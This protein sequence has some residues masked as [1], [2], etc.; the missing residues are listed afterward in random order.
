MFA[1]SPYRSAYL[2]RTPREKSYSSRNSSIRGVS[3]SFFI[4]SPFFGCRQPSI[5]QTNRV[6]THRVCDDHK[7]VTL[8]HAEKD[9]SVLIE[10]VIRVGNGH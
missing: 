9:E 7:P 5:D 10:R 4:P 3:G 2:P 8:G 1:L 6:A